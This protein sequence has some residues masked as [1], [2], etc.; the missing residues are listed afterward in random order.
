MY[1]CDRGKLLARAGEPAAAAGA[2]SR[3][4]RSSVMTDMTG[5]L[6]QDDEDESLELLVAALRMMGAA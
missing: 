4:R 3:N 5:R 6:L 1:P 2:R